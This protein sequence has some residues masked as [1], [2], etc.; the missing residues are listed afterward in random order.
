MVRQKDRLKDILDIYGADVE[1]VYSIYRANSS[2]DCERIWEQICNSYP[3]LKDAGDI[4]KEEIL[5][6]LGKNKNKLKRG[7]L[8]K[9]RFF[10][11]QGRVDIGSL[12]SHFFQ[13]YRFVTTDD[14]EEIYYYENGIYRP[15]D[16]RIKAE[17]ESLLGSS[18][19]SYLVN[20]IIQHL[21]R[22]SYVSRE[23]INKLNY[24]PVKNGILN[25]D[26]FE[27]Q[28]FNPGQIFTYKLN[29]EYDP[30]ATCSNFKKFLSEVLMK[31]DIPIVQEF[32]GYCL[33]PA[34]PAHKTLWLYGIGR[35]GKTTLINIFISILSKETIVSVPLEEL[36]GGHRFTIARF[37]G[38]LVNIT[39]EPSTRKAMQSV[40]LKKLSG[41]DLLSAEVKNKQ[42]TI[43]FK[44]FAKFVIL[45]NFFPQISDP[46]LAF[47]DRL[48]VIEFPYTF[49]DNAIPDL[50]KKIV[51]QDGLA[52]I[53]NWCLEG[54][55]RLKE[56]NFHFKYSKKSEEMRL[57]FEKCSDPVSAFIAEGCLFDEEAVIPKAVLYEA[58]KD[59]CR[60]DNLFIIGKGEFTKRIQRYSNMTECIQKIE[61]KSQR[62]WRGIKLKT[63]SEEGG[64]NE[65]EE[66]KVA[67][68]AEVGSIKFC[69]IVRKS[70]CGRCGKD[71]WLDHEWIKHEGEKCLIC[72]TCA[73]E[74]KGE[75][76]GGH[77][78]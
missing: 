62:C 35:N 78:R 37:F 34:M 25:L 29:A 48:I 64:G 61:G 65:L 5:E 68:E 57:E 31:D 9:A 7:A 20:E 36:D 26:T 47:W 74:L 24:L 8:D 23:E 15:A 13:K 3:S 58:Y 77:M 44:N 18:A 69:S 38:K 66:G 41:G 50:D 28:S 53:L 59:Y 52:G 71:T 55:K 51:E 2:L 1:R 72:P 4:D 22:S 21:K 46:S 39:S 73:S 33:Y 10:D 12:L 19:S 60:S 11:E 32:L 43:E 45:G 76:G 63:S 6:I 75:D 30:A 42:K 16:V 56:R 49:L 14:T 40:V 17:M 67:D 54:L 27:L 70:K